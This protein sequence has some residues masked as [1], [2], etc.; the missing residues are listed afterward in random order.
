MSSADEIWIN[1]NA[2]GV[3]PDEGPAR[4]ELVWYMM[5]GQTVRSAAVF[6]MLAEVRQ[7]QVLSGVH[8]V[9][10]TAAARELVTA[11]TGGVFNLPNWSGW[12]VAEPISCVGES[13]AL[14]RGR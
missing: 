2:V 14:V 4:L 9:H 12:E 10:V 6:Q 3:A 11:R 7:L 13:G 5:H 1:V 8:R